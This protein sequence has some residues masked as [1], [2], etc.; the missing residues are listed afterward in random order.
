MKRIDDTEYKF[1]G[2]RHYDKGKQTEM[3]NILLREYK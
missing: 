1:P 2:V 3:K